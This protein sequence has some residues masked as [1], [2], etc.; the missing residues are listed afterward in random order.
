MALL[1]FEQTNFLKGHIRKQIRKAKVE[2]N[3]DELAMFKS[4]LS[5]L[6]KDEF[7]ENAKE[8]VLLVMENDG[9][10]LTKKQLEQVIHRVKNYDH[11]GYNEFISD[12]IAEVLEKSKVS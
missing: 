9:V 10:K 4:I 8:D 12:T 7:Y 11:S 1:N 2:E 3:Q 5:A 6:N